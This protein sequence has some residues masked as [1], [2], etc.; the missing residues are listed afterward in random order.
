MEHQNSF[1]IELLSE[2]SYLRKIFILPTKSLCKLQKTV[3]YLLFSFIKLW[4]YRNSHKLMIWS[5][6]LDPF[7]LEHVPQSQKEAKI[8]QALICNHPCKI[9]FYMV[10]MSFYTVS[11]LVGD[12]VHCITG[13]TSFFKFKGIVHLT[14]PRFYCEIS[15]QKITF[16]Q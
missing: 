1:F 9:V 12:R 5:V 2:S 11:F 7:V 15:I 13:S 8:N 3:L 14:V 16:R 10:K 4:N 6:V